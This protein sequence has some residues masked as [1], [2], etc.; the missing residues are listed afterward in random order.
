MPLSGRRAQAAR[1]DELILDA[2]R[3]VFVADPGAPIGEVARRAGVG[4]SA[5]YSRY[6]SKEELLR[7]ICRDG[8]QRFV[9]ETESA[10][11]D[12]RDSWT[13]FTDYVQRLVDAD[14]SSLTLAL[15]GRFEPNEEMFALA[16]RANR[17]SGRLFRR[18]KAVVRPGLEVH[19]LSLVFELLAAIKL[20]D[21]RRTQQLRRRYL[22]VVL[23]GLR[24]GG[25][26]PLPGPPP[27]WQ[28]INERWAS[29][30]APA[31]LHSPGPRRAPAPQRAPAPTSPAD[32]RTPAAASD[33][34][35]RPA[36]RR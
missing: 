29:E 33:R 27:R 10:L 22:A 26:D 28:E 6:P 25:G 16:E 2:A 21:P 19:D 1:N 14:T 18:F 4:I 5:L 7:K 24:A 8:L 13:V 15:A 3:E 36:R 12:Q 35:P 11:D 30:G 31:R 34:A 23:D 9:E 17:L 32:R 20:P